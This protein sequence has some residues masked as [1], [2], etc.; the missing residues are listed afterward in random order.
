MLA[1]TVDCVIYSSTGGKKIYNNLYNLLRYSGNFLKSRQFKTV[2]A[3][4]ITL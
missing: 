3:I 4:N 1:W 2:T